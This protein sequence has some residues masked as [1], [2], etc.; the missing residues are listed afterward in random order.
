MSSDDTIGPT[1]PYFSKEGWMRV[2]LSTTG[3]MVLP[4]GNCHEWAAVYAGWG[5]SR[6]ELGKFP[7]RAKAEEFCIT[8]Y[9]LRG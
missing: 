5:Q 9:N 2:G 8:T 7:T 3:F 4:V 1:T 6:E